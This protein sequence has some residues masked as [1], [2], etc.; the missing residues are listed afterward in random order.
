MIKAEASDTYLAQVGWQASN[1]P[2]CT[3]YSPDRFLRGLDLLIHK[4]PNDNR[5]HRLWPIL[6]FDLE[7]NMHNK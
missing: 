3:G 2:W 5:V 7:A 6:L 4:K 1:F